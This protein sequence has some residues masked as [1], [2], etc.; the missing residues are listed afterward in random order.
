[1]HTQ[2]CSSTGSKPSSQ[3]S[4]GEERRTDLQMLNDKD[5]EAQS[6][7]L[8][9][10]DIKTDNVTEVTRNMDQ[11]NGLYAQDEYIDPPPDGGYGWVSCACVALTNFATWGPNTSWGVFLSYFLTHDYF[12]GATTTDFALIGGLVIGLTL[13]L[14]PVASV[15]MNIFGYKPT[16][17]FAIV[18]EAV[19][20]VSSSFTRSIGVLYVTY[21]VLLGLSFGIIF[22]TNT[23]IIPGWF[24]R[25]RALANGI[26]HVG[27]GL[28]GLVFSFAVRAMIDR[29]G[30]HRWAMRMLAAA[31]LFINCIS[32]YFVRVRKQKSEQKKTAKEIFKN[33]FD[34]SVFK[35]VP[36]HLCALWSSTSCM[37]YV[38]LMFSM[39]NFATSI[40]MSSQQ[41][42]IALAV[43]NGSQAV[44]R[45]FMGWSSE[46]L[47][48][49]NATILIMVYNLI[50]LLPFWFTI[51]KFREL[52]PF[53]FLLGFGAGVGSVNV[54][55]LVSDVVGIKRFSAG[56]GYAFFG[57]GI[58]SIFA[59]V[60]ALH[61]RTPSS[62]RPYLRCQIFVVFMYFGGLLC[63]L[64]YRE[65]KMRRIL[66]AKA[67]NKQSSAQQKKEYQDLLDNTCYNYIR[68][69]FYLVKA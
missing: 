54:V 4:D 17:A 52:V 68:R 1:M 6:E 23:I 16:L 67:N 46:R 38:I 57:N 51:T 7:S 34:K 56:I 10:T 9:K 36:L 37:G 60:I 48:R 3:S 33:A 69:T 30:D 13:F 44:G 66:A 12:P 65:L 35:I 5:L 25:K 49:C 28:G 11:D 45:P 27:I 53:C 18:L 24:L 40:G 58:A 21:G 15:C 20:F 62:P 19:A 64:P 47:G 29:T 26:S 41:A 31:T 2:N 59:E 32:L 39:A 55:P 50:L 61:L 42:T 8:G 22:G 43:F 63:L 14:L